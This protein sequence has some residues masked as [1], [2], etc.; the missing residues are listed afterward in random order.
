VELQPMPHEANM[1][2]RE[3]D[4]AGITNQ[5]QR[6]KL[7]NRLNKRVCENAAALGYQFDWLICAVISPFGSDGGLGPVSTYYPVALPRSLAPTS[8]QLTTRHH[9]WIDLFPLARM[10]DNLLVATRILSPADEQRLYEDIMT[11]GEAGSEWAGLLVWGEPWDPQSWEVSLPFLQRWA[12]VLRGC[13]EIIMSTNRWR[14]RRGERPIPT[15][16]FVQEE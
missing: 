15:S 11:S 4:W 12:W 1:R 2:H 3:E 8:M 13:P 5:K 14:C 9:P 16:G 6:K 10:R 7:Q